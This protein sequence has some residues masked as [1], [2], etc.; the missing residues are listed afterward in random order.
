M[1]QKLGVALSV[2]FISSACFAMGMVGAWVDPILVRQDV[3]RVGSQGA[4]RL[5]GAGTPAEVA[6]GYSTVQMGTHDASRTADV[7]SIENVLDPW[8]PIVVA[9]SAG[10][11][12][13]RL[14]CLRQDAS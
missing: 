3:T 5:A 13:I 6:S 11:I 8:L 12:V 10:V 7:S 4:S 1:K 14:S 9:L 2:L